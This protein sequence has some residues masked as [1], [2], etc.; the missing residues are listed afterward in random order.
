MDPI[1]VV[2]SLIP[3]L[4]ASQKEEIKKLLG[5][6]EPT[7]CEKTGHKYGKVL[8]ITESIFKPK[9]MIQVCSKCGHKL[10]IK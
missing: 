1:D 6:G 4:T 3:S 10:E 2:K 5:K 9:K 7:P 8:E